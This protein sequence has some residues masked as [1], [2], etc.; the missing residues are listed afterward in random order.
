MLAQILPTILPPLSPEEQ[1]ELT[2]TASI[3]EYLNPSI[4][5]FV[6]RPFREPHSS[7]FAP[8]IVEEGKYSKP[9][10]I[11]LAHLVFRRN[12]RV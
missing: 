6:K 8:A 10:E 3:A 2:I 4:D 5:L 9:G 11:T 12:A 1:L 7:S